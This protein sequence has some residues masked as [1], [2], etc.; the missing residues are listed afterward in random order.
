MED[1]LWQSSDMLD[2]LD[3]MREDL[4]HND[5]A[6]DVGGAKKGMDQHNELRRKILKVPVENVDNVGQRILQRLSSG[7]CG[8]SYDSGYSGRDS[9]ASNMTCNPDM[10]SCIPQIM[11]LLDQVHSGQQQ[12]LQLW[13]IKKA[14][15]DQCL[16]LR[17]FEQECEKMFDWIYHNRD[18]FLSNYVDIGH[19]YPIAKKLQEDHNHF[20]LASNGIYTNINRILSEAGELIKGGHYAASHVRGVAARLDKAWKE[21]AGGLDE[22]TTVLALSVMFHQKAEQVRFCSIVFVMCMEF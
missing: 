1:F 17:L 11:Q 2:R 10:Q 20:T 21:F 19:S 15:L 12:L 22:R 4:A 16:Q 5:F 6:D 9:S 18:V 14:K 7:E 3:D 8:N 13:Q